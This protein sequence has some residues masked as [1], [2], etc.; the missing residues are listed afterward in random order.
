LEQ[1]TAEIIGGAFLPGRGFC[2]ETEGGE[3]V[4]VIEEGARG[5]VALELEG[6]EEGL[7]EAV[8]WG[9]GGHGME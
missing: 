8:G 4:T 6:I 7:E 9:A 1:V 5:D 2:L 3:G